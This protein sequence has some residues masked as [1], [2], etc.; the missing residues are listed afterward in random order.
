MLGLQGA[1]AGSTVLAAAALEPRILQ[2]RSDVMPLC[3]LIDASASLI[4]AVTA[5]AAG[6]Q[7]SRVT[8]HLGQ[9][10]APKGTLHVRDQSI[11]VNQVWPDLGMA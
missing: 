1:Y 3:M 7:R 9:S 10:A 2:A 5:F 8:R 11:T 4:Q 6:L